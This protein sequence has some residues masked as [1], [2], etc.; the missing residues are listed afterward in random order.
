MMVC[1]K[2]NHHL[3]S[4]CWRCRLEQD[5]APM[6]EGLSIYKVE[7]ILHEHMMNCAL[8]VEYDQGWYAC[9]HS[10]WEQIR[11]LRDART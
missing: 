3:L 8:D 11:K 1:L 5:P 4:D 7:A 9:A 10:I 6:S 2:H